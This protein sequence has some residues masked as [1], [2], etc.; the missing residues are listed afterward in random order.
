LLAA[1]AL[2]ATLQPPPLVFHHVHVRVEDPAAAMQRYVRA[3]GCTEV[4][5]PGLGPGVQCGTVYILFDRT[6]AASRPSS[7]PSARRGWVIVS[8]RGDNATVRV[9]LA[10]DDAMAAR[11]WL[12]RT[13]A[14]QQVPELSLVDASSVRQPPTDD[15][16]HVAFGAID[17]D[18]VRR[19]IAGS[20]VRVDAGASLLASPFGLPLEIVQDDDRGG[21]LFWCPMHPDVRANREGRCPRCGMTLVPIASA[22]LGAYR[23]HL[24]FAPAGSARGRLTLRIVDPEGQPAQGFATVHDRLLHLF[25]VSRDLTFFQHVHPDAAG[26]AAFAVDLTLPGPG[27]YGVFADFSP[28]GGTPQLLQSTLVTPDYRGPAFADP[29]S[30]DSGSTR[31]SA[32]GLTFALDAAKLVAGRPSSIA[33]SVTSAASGNPIADLEPY[34]GAAGHLLIVSDDLEYAI[35]A[36]PSGA[37]SV[38]GALRFDAT[39]PRAGMYKMWLQVQRG[40]EVITVAFVVRVEGRLPESPASAPTP[41]V[42]P[43]WRFPE[44]GSSGDSGNRSSPR[45]VDTHPTVPRR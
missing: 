10:L 24:D 27:V 7:S 43:S 37:T 26:V 44:P 8:G 16:T 5:L 34:L 11:E 13:L 40:G 42:A 4:V 23:M 25:V 21:D 15:I 35:H 2:I 39:L 32:S 18:D 12:D 31:Q 1:L 17:A 45:H 28:A 3:N 30:L 19:R 9:R 20:G 41:G 14:I 6:D 33:F 22:A 29:P 38:V 36:H